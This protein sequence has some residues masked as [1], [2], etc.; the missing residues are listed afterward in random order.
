LEQAVV[1]IDAQNDK[2]SKSEIT[3]DHT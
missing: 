1:S 3:Y 2:P